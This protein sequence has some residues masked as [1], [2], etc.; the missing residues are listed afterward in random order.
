MHDHIVVPISRDLSTA[1]VSAHGHVEEN[2]H[3]PHG[4]R[5]GGNLGLHDGPAVDVPDHPA[6]ACLPARLD[7]GKVVLDRAVLH[8]GDPGAEDSVLFGFVMLTPVEARV[9]FEISVPCLGNVDFTIYRPGEWLLREEP[10]GWP[11]A[12]GAR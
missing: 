5:A 4:P 10:E 9:V 2:R 1:H 8:V 11:D 6:L 12:L 7:P 3:V